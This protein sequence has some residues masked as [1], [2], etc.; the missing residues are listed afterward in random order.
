[1]SLPDTPLG[2]RHASLSTCTPLPRVCALEVQ[3]SRLTIVG[4]VRERSVVT[5][6]GRGKTVCAR[7]AYWALLCSPS[8]S[9]LEVSRHPYPRMARVPY[10]GYTF[11]GEPKLRVGSCQGRAEP[12]E[13]RRGV[14]GRAA[15][16]PGSS[17]CDRQGS[18]A[19]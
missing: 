11:G 9:P 5:R 10:V 14:C 13:A 19:Q 15:R 1:M 8:T 6:R 16:F 12:A 17:T 2:T 3:L 7:G 18:L 4:G